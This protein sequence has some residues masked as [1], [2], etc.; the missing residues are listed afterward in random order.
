M[1]VFADQ[2]AADVAQIAKQLHL[3]VIQLHGVEPV[4]Y[5]SGLAARASCAIWKS[6][7]P[8]A[9]DDL[10]QAIAEYGPHV[11]GVLLDSGA[12][13]GRRFDWS[14][15]SGVRALLP[16]QVV[17]VVAGGLR[18]ENVSDAVAA[19]R[20]DVVDVASGVECAVCEKDVMKVRAFVRNARS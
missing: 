19:L 4:A 14:L 3:D 15:A 7:F 17:L 18:P 12:G 20:P 13:T 16:A 11:Q 9:A 5:V 1:G 10:A 2:P 8:H 6:V